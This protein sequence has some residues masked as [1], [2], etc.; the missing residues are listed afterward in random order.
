MVENVC[1]GVPE[2]GSASI[3]DV[4]DEDF[5]LALRQLLEATANRPTSEPTQA[6]TA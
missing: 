4:E 5:L 1:N 2:P 3:W 6:L